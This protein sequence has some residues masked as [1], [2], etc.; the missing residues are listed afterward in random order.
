MD[1]DATAKQAM[2]DHLGCSLT[3]LRAE[4][5]S[6]GYPW[7]DQH[8]VVWVMDAELFIR[9]CVITEDGQGLVF[10]EPWELD[11]INALFS[12]EEIELPGGPAPAELA[13]CLR[14]LL[15]GP[16]GFVGTAAELNVQRQG[17][18]SWLR[19]EHAPD[20]EEALFEACFRD[21]T[22]SRAGD[23][24][25]LGFFYFTREGGVERW[26]VSGDGGAITEL[27]VKAHVDDGRFRYPYM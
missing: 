18:T 20:S 19:P 11:R 9:A 15:R 7:F 23:Q 24:W 26:E 1:L 16:G 13:R 22:L 2:A 5:K 8:K 25:T 14:D 12:A 17:L 3:A 27:E 6:H 10:G 21:P 4:D